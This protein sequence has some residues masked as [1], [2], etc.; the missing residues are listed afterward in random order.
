MVE[1]SAGFVS[2]FLKAGFGTRGARSSR[3]PSLCT[4]LL[5]K[6][7]LNRRSSEAQVLAEVGCRVFHP[8]T[9]LG[10]LKY[11]SGA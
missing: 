9:F 8:L 6:R 3:A 2:A 7:C 4:A 11:Y 10:S 5:K 1:T